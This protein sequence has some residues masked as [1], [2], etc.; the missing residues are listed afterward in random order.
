MRDGDDIVIA[1]GSDRDARLSVP[2]DADDD[3]SDES[4][5]VST[6]FPRD[7]VDS[8]FLR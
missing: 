7:L 1:A 8:D 4:A 2:D 6:P 3:A 5:S